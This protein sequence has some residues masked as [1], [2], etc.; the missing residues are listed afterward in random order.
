MRKIDRTG[1]VVYNK[2]GDRTEIVKYENACRVHVK[3]NDK[4]V[5]TNVHFQNCVSKQHLV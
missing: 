3:V 1:E 4:I 5:I 2:Y